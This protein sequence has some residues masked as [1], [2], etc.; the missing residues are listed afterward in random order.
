MDRKM[1]KW[2]PFESVVSTNKVMKEVMHEKNKIKKPILSIEQ[3]EDIEN[4][5]INAYRDQDNI[6]ISYYEKGYIYNINS[7]IKKIDCINKL[8]YLNNKIIYFNQITNVY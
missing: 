2:A 7:Y 6:N 3:V 4:K 1:L 8:V 5:I